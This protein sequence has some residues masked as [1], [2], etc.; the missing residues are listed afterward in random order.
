MRSP[1]LSLFVGLSHGALYCLL[2]H[3]SAERTYEVIEHFKT[4]GLCFCGCRYDIASNRWLR[5]ARLPGTVLAELSCRLV[6]LG[7]EL[8]VIPGGPVLDCGDALRTFRK[9]K[10]A[11]VFQVYDPKTRIWRYVM[12]RPPLARARRN[13]SMPWGAMCTIKL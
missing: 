12:T 8:Y 3:S 2:H 5:E 13:N 6:A 10:G 7:G 1:H 11:L 4:F 9:K